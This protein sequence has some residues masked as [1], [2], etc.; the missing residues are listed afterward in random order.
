MKTFISAQETAARLAISVA[1]LTRWRKAGQGP[2][3]YRIGKM[4]KYDEAEVTA[5]IQSC[6]LEAERFQK[7]L[8]ALP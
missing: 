5:Y 3:A 4:W 1:T 2:P 7:I 6:R 8:N